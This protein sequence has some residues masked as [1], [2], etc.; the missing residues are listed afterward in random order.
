LLFFD[1]PECVLLA[2]R[3]SPRERPSDNGPVPL[4]GAPVLRGV[5]TLAATA[6]G[7]LDRGPGRGGEPLRRWKRGRRRRVAAR[8]ASAGPSSDGGID[9]AHGNEAAS[10]A[11]REPSGRRRGPRSARQAGGRRPDP[12]GEE[13]FGPPNSLCRVGRLGVRR[14]SNRGDAGAGSAEGRGG[15]APEIRRRCCGLV[16]ADANSMT[17]TSHAEIQSPGPTRDAAPAGEPVAGTE[18]RRSVAGRPGVR[19]EPG[20]DEAP[21]VRG[22]TWGPAIRHIITVSNT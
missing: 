10:Q 9:A 3:S 6:A 11:R 13:M 19:G 22:A 8:R 14:R 12:G 21:G 4:L 17:Y 15:T 2:S 5:V 1:C 7:V 16:L 18:A 20:L